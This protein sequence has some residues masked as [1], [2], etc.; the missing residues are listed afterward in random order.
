M[1][2]KRIE[3][4]VATANKLARAYHIKRAPV[5]HAGVIKFNQTQQVAQCKK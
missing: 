3:R 2:T 5:T 1:T 4:M